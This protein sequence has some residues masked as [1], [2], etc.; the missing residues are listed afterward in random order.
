MRMTLILRA[1]MC[2]LLALTACAP[3]R[4]EAARRAPNVV[5]VMTDDQGYGELSCHGNPYLKTPNLDRLAAAS[6][7]LSDFHV[8]PMCTPTRGQ[9]LSGY[10]AMRNGAM[11]VSS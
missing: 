8:A 9:L 1:T 2:G 7:R 5:I 10:H 6:A 3:A 4:S 11:N